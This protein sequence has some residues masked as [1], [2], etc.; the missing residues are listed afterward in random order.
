MSLPQRVILYDSTGAPLLVGAASGGDNSDGQAVAATGRLIV[1]S[2]QYIYDSTAGTWSRAKSIASTGDGAAATQT[3]A[4]G[5]MMVNSAGTF[6]R[7]RGDTSGGLIVSHRRS[8]AYGTSQPAANTGATITLA[9]G[10]SGVFHFITHI[11]IE[12]SATAALA[13]T[14]SLNITTT[15]LGGIAWKTGNAMVAGGTQIDVDTEYV[16]PLRSAVSNTATTIVLP[17]P[18]AA[19]LYS[20]FVVYYLGT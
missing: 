5:P 20:A 6:D 12:R 3:M 10:G 19:V 8:T 14:A 18:G 16:H 15:N 17:A 2:R 4:V 11:R 7:M 1:V 13:G 9:A